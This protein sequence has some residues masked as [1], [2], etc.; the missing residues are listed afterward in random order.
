MTD[1]KDD[2]SW[3]TRWAGPESLAHSVLDRLASIGRLSDHDAQALSEDWIQSRE[4]IQQHFEEQLDASV[5]ERLAFWALPRSRELRE[6]RMRIHDLTQ[7]ADQLE[8]I[9]SRRRDP[10]GETP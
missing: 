10:R 8:T 3:R 2:G 9:L 1:V 6:L 5:R 4:E 7:R